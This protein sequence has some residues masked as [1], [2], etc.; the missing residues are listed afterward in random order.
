M[1]L[2]VIT[3]TI[4]CLIAT[5]CVPSAYAGG[6]FA[7]AE[8]GSG[9]ALRWEND[10]LRWCADPGDLSDDVVHTK[11]IL[12]RFLQLPHGTIAFSLIRRDSCSLLE[13]SPSLHGI[14]AESLIH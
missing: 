2:R 12:P 7:V 11:H 9:T 8:D 5:L 13:E 14:Q 10:T 6:P 3:A 4:A 1:R